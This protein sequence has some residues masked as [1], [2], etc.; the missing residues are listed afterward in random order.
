MKE[1]GII[2]KNTNRIAFT[3]ANALEFVSILKKIVPS[4][5]PLGGSSLVQKF[6]KW[7]SFNIS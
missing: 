6:R 3:Q 2:D 1:H 7:V 5:A 4:M